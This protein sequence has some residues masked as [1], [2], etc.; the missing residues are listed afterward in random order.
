MTKKIRSYIP[1]KNK[2]RAEL[3]KEINSVCPFCDNDDVG[4]FEIHHIDEIPSNNEPYNLLLLCP[5]CHSKITKNEISRVKV[6]NI[7]KS[8]LG[9]ESEVR[10]I[11]VSLDLKNCGWDYI[12][13]ITGA[14][15]FTNIHKYAYPILNFSLINNSGKTVLLTNIKIKSK[16]LPVGLSGPSIPLPNVLKPSIKYELEIPK[17]TE[18]NNVILENEIEIPKS[19]AFKF[20]TEFYCKYKKSVYPPLGKYVLYLELYFNNDFNIEVPPI[21]FNCKSEDEQLTY[22]GLV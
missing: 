1:Q 4:H 15:Q 18:T 20:Q 2:V 12:E 6:Q 13:G 11:S 7:K 21:L 22:Y 9:K 14:Y 16:I 17:N 10:L 3:Q 8:L 5:I 19:R